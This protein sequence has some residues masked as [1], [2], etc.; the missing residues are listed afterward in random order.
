MIAADGTPPL[1]GE[2]SQPVLRESRSIGFVCGDEGQRVSNGSAAST[3]HLKRVCAG[4]LEPRR[5]LQSLEAKRQLSDQS[6]QKRQF[7]PRGGF[8]ALSAIEKQASY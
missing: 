4:S 1:C 7:G 6:E 5:F 3:S 2:G 8:A